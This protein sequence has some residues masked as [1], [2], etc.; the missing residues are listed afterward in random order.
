VFRPERA[1]E[2]I[3][4]AVA[5]MLLEMTAQIKAGSIGD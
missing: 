4:V 5:F 2:L 3:E 1:A